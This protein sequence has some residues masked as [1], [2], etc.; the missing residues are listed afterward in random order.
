MKGVRNVC[1]FFQKLKLRA[2]V[3]WQGTPACLE[4]M[5]VRLYRAE[6]PGQVASA[7]ENMARLAYDSQQLCAVLLSQE[8]LG[9]KDFRELAK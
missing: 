4:A 7:V 2:R 9:A 1:L 5:G 6:E 3:T 8:L